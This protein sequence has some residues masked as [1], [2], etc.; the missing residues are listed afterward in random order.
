MTKYYNISTTSDWIFMIK[1]SLDSSYQCASNRIIFM[2]LAL[3]DKM[4]LAFIK[5][6]LFIE[7]C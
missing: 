4:L 6:L 3:I 5:F 1:D 2:P 7:L